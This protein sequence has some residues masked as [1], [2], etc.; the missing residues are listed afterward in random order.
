MFGNISEIR[1]SGSRETVAGSRESPAMS[2]SIVMH[3]PT[4]PRSFY[5]VDVDVGGVEGG[6][7]N[8]LVFH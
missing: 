3:S 6:W 1:G 5:N 4:C 2:S 8:R 7:N